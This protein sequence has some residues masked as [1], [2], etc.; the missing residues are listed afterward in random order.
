M[1]WSGRPGHSTIT[2]HSAVRKTL[3][4]MLWGGSPVFCPGVR[5]ATCGVQ[6]LIQRLYTHDEQP[7]TLPNFARFY[8]AIQ[9]RVLQFYT[10]NDILD[11]HQ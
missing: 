3:G 6:R 9:R 11:M 4:S 7:F 2:V 1:C 8:V 5:E 10:I